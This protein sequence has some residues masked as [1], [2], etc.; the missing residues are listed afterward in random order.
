MPK[1]VVY[2]KEIFIMKKFIVLTIL[3]CTVMI[4]STASAIDKVYFNGDNNYLF[5]GYTQ[6][7]AFFVDRNTLN[8]EKYSP[9]I[10]IISVAVVNVRNYFN[11]GNQ[12]GSRR[13]YRFKY[14]YL[15]RKMYLYTPEGGESLRKRYENQYRNNPQKMNEARDIDWNSEWTYVFP[16]VFYGE[17]AVFPNVGEIAFALAY[18]IKFHT[19][20][21]KRYQGNFYDGVRGVV[22][23]LKDGI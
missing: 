2:L 17:G 12:L 11:G 13:N 19:K 20:E 8:V 7:V 3:L 16:E 1:F 6:G 9:P 15:T 14:D 4:S 23:E 21:H 22:G 18:K 10:Y 5:C